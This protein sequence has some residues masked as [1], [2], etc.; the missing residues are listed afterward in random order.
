MRYLSKR[1]GVHI[2]MH[3]MWGGREHEEYEKDL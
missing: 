2:A 1:I 3:G